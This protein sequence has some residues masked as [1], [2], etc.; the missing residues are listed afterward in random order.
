MIQTAALVAVRAQAVESDVCVEGVSVVTLPLS[1]SVR[2]LSCENA[3]ASTV[4]MFVP[5]AWLRFSV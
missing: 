1:G 2:L 5:V 3:A 4:P